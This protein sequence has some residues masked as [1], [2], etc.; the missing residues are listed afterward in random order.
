M[1]KT[2]DTARIEYSTWIVQAMSNLKI[3]FCGLA[4]MVPEIASNQERGAIK[5]SYLAAIPMNS[6]TDPL[7]KTSV[8]VQYL[9]YI[10][11]KQQLFN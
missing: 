4:S 9:G 3:P 6:N 2:E 11:D 8:K 7:G 10:G 1:R 5:S